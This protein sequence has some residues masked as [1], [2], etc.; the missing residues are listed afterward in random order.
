MDKM[1]TLLPEEE[2]PVFFFRGLFMDR[3]PA[4]IRSHLLTESI[5]DPQRMALQA[6]ELWTIRG[7]SGAFHVVSD[8]TFQAIN[9]L[10]CKVFFWRTEDKTYTIAKPFTWFFW[11]SLG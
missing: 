4:D 8:E 2:K 1:L 5:S 11:G 9:A 7:K 10:Q 3:L 6:D